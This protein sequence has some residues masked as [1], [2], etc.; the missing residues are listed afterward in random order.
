MCPLSPE[1][2]PIIQ[3]SNIDE[4]V[5]LLYPSSLR[6]I[7][8]ETINQSNIID[9]N[10]EILYA[11]PTNEKPIETINQKVSPPLAD[12]NPLESLNLNNQQ[13]VTGAVL[14]IF[15]KISDIDT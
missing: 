15:P 14:T 11:L 7:P 3:T 9:E 2:N 12:K 5:E 13:I 4:N 8:L 1:E 6:E 10:V